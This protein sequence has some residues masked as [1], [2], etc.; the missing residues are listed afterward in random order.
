M[1][2]F[3]WWLAY[4][5]ITQHSWRAGH[6]RPWRFLWCWTYIRVDSDELSNCHRCELPDRDSLTPFGDVTRGC[7]GYFVLSGFSKRSNFDLNRW[8]SH[9]PECAS[10]MAA[11]V[12]W[13]AMHR[14]SMPSN[15][16]RYS[17]PLR[18]TNLVDLLLISNLLGRFINESTTLEKIQLD[19][20]VF[21]CFYSYYNATDSSKLGFKQC[22]WRRG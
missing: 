15:D 9:M 4:S 6:Y 20:L 18:T 21:G 16:H 1:V 12:L 17:T 14:R 19:P 3:Y 2:S 22:F 5:Y 13:F 10:L 8:A 7:L 11:C